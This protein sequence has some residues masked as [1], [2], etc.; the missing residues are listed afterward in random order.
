MDASSLLLAAQLS[1][2]LNDASIH[3]RDPGQAFCYGLQLGF[4]AFLF[5]AYARRKLLEFAGQFTY[6]IR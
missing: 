5:V 2:L 3:L 4:L 6:L 1:N